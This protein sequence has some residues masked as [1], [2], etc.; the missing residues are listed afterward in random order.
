VC[1]WKGQWITNLGLRKGKISHPSVSAAAS[2]DTV[3]LLGDADD[4]MRVTLKKNKQD[5]LCRSLGPLCTF[6]TLESTLFPW[7]SYMAVHSSLCTLQTCSSPDQLFVHQYLVPG[8]PRIQKLSFFF[9]KVVFHFFEGVVFHFLIFFEVVFQFF[10]EVIFHFFL[11]VVFH[12]Y[13]I[14]EM[15]F[16]LVRPR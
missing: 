8:W 6:W 11:E 7:N 1:G 2:V 13:F 10:F 4:V 15:V 16:H 5:K 14:F 12:F 3:S 9:F